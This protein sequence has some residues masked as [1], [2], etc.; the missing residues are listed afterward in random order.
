ME[1][2]RKAEA[3]MEDLR[4]KKK[5]LENKKNKKGGMSADET[6]DKIAHLEEKAQTRKKV[7]DAVV[8][9]VETNTEYV[10]KQEQK[11]SSGIIYPSPRK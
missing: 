8:K 1:Q 4:G 9:N 5:E 11:L 6:D 7:I 2:I 10:N 3:E